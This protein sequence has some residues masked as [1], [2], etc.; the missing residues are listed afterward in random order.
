MYFGMAF[1][2]IFG[3]LIGMSGG[4]S[5]PLIIFYTALVRYSTIL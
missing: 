4:E 3:G 2:P 1:G 5:R